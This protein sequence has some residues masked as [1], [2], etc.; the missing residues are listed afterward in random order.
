M[1]ERD[2]VHAEREG[3]K[4]I[5]WFFK[6]A[7][8]LAAFATVVLLQ[9]SSASTA[10]AQTA[11]GLNP[12]EM[13]LARKAV[14]PEGKLTDSQRNLAALG[15]IY[16]YWAN[17]GEPEK[18]QRVAFQMLQHY[19]LV[20]QRYAAIVAQAKQQ[21]SMNLATKAALKAYTNVPDG[22][23]VRITFDNDS[24]RVI[25]HHVDADG[26]DIQKN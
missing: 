4:M 9:V 13:E 19:R 7:T 1:P 25:Y 23:D 15:S 10:I 12:R 22:R 24:E 14:D 11:G 16:Q 2:A 18:A 3:A 6:G 5:R 17:K 26:R 8:M 21:A 20:S